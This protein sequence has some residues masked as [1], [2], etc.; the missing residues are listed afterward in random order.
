MSDLHTGIYP[1]T[2]DPFT[3]GHMDIVRRAMHIVDKLIIGV[4]V[5]TEKSPM[6]T[7][8]ERVEMVKEETN[9]LKKSQDIPATKI[10]EV[11]PF[12]NVLVTFAGSLG[13][14]VIIRGIRAVSDFEF[15]FKMAGMNAK[16][17]KN[18]ETVFLMASDHNQFTS[19]QLVKEIA[20]L[21]GNITDFVSSRV[22]KRLL[23]HLK[24]VKD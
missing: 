18:I 15:E 19:S 6:F 24:G 22:E 13:A 7:F 10:I 12:K 3:N 4:A 14:S 9:S 2:F 1:G 8:E 23:E 17:D 11:K 21:G 5:N 20:R 16:L